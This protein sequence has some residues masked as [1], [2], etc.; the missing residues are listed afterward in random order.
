MKS[1]VYSGG[2]GED[3]IHYFTMEEMIKE[4]KRTVVK[5]CEDGNKRK[6]LGSVELCPYVNDVQGGG[7]RFWALEGTPLRGFVIANYGLQVVVAFD[8]HFK[9][10]KIK[11]GAKI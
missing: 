9:R 11:R 6:W 10:L 1:P 7:V 2:C 8:G 3:S 4:A 5:A